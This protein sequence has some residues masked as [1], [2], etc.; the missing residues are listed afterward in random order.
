M[1]V[2]YIIEHCSDSE[3]FFSQKDDMNFEEYYENMAED[4]TWV[5]HC[6]IYTASM[7]TQT[8]IHVHHLKGQ[9]SQINN[10]DTSNTLTFYVSY[11]DENHYNN[12]NNN[13]NAPIAPMLLEDDNQSIGHN[14]Q[15]PIKLIIDEKG[16]KNRQKLHRR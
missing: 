3:T 15:E 10:F 8:N 1:V 5:D 11:H 13:V 16:A 7:P 9:V 12:I 6:E 2:E 14:D 4:R